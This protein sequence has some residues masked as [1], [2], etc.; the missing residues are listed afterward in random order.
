MKDSQCSWWRYRFNTRDQGLCS[1]FTLL[2]PQF[3]AHAWCIV[4]CV[5]RSVVC[6]TPHDP[7]DCSL[8]GFSI[9]SILQ[10]RIL[11]WVAISFPR[12]LPHPVIKPRSPIAGRLFTCFPGVCT[13]CFPMLCWYLIVD[14]E[15]CGGIVHFRTLTAT[16]S[17][18]RRAPHWV[19]L[20]HSP[21]PLYEM[22]K[23]TLGNGWLTVLQISSENEKH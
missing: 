13:S 1:P 21:C 14:G 18:R 16:F 9:H 5:S 11:G 7:M 3:W 8:P 17:A 4:G 2:C 19:T 10:A 22:V 15:E 6:L 12:D 20:H 23:A